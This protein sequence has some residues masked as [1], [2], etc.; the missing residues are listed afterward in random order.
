MIVGSNVRR[1]EFA[2]QQTLGFEETA[3]EELRPLEKGRRPPACEGL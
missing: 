3:Q 2:L 1:V